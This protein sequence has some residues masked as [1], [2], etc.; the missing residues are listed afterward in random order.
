MIGERFHNGK[1]DDIYSRLPDEF[2]LDDARRVKPE[3]SANSIRQMMKNWKNQGLVL[4]V[5]PGRYKK[6]K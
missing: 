6:N 5:S 4:M 1:N 3:A 2:T